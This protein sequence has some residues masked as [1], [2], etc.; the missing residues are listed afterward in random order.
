MPVS[1]SCNAGFTVY[2]DTIPNTLVVVNSSTGTNLSY[3]WD[4]GDGT[5]LTSPT[6]S[7]VYSTNGPYFLCLSIDDGTG[8][9]STYCDSVSNTGSIFKAFGFTINV[10]SANDISTSIEENGNNTISIFPIP[11]NEKLNISYQGN[12]E[13]D[14]KVFDLNGKRYDVKLTS[15]NTIDVSFLSAGMYFIQISIESNNSILKF[16]KN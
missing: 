13:L 4:F 12:E 10:I 16:I 2:P 15:P 8:C 11:V 6:P 5:I 14:V 9:T 1:L 7:H 3:S